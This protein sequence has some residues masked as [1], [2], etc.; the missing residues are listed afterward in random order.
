MQDLIIYPLKKSRQGRR[1]HVEFFYH[2]K[3]HC[4]RKNHVEFFPAKK[5]TAAVK[6]TWSFYT[7]K[8]SGAGQTWCQINNS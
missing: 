2:E 5:R 8:K 1:Y 3:K 6:I 7:Q 4:I